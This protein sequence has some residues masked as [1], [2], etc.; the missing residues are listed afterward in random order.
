MPKKRRIIF[1]SI[2]FLSLFI[3]FISD[4]Q[5]NIKGIYALLSQKWEISEYIAFPGW[6]KRQ[7]ILESSKSE[8][9]DKA[10]KFIETTQCDFD[11]APMPNFGVQSRESILKSRI[12]IKTYPWPFRVDIMLNALFKKPEIVLNEYITKIK[13]VNSSEMKSIIKNNESASADSDLHD[14]TYIYGNYLLVRKLIGEINENESIYKRNRI[15]EKV[16]NI[17]NSKKLNEIFLKHKISEI[18]NVDYDEFEIA[19]YHSMQSLYNFFMLLKYYS[20]SFILSNSESVFEKMNLLLEYL[21]YQQKLCTQIR[22]FYEQSDE[23]TTEVIFY[24]LA[25]ID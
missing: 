15:Y 1:I 17:S 14:I 24:N 22:I 12:C 5:N 23:D 19:T 9:R 10:I 8:L 20:N 11:S 6:V 7:L 2:L 3:F 25:G 13:S 16:V 21:Y 4:I 18:S